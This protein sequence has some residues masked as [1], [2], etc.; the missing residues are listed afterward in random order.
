MLLLAEWTEAQSSG[1]TWM[2]AGVTQQSDMADD[3]R[4]AQIPSSGFMFNPWLT[5]SNL[6]VKGLADNLVSHWHFVDRNRQRNLKLRD[7]KHRDDIVRAV[8]ANLAYALAARYEPPTVYVSLRAA[9]QKSSPRYDRDGFRGLPRVLDLLAQYNLLHLERS[10]KK[11]VASSI[12]PSTQ[13]ME[14]PRGRVLAKLQ[15][16][17]ELPGRET[18]YL[19]RVD[20]DYAGASETRELIDYRETP[21]TTR[22]R[23]EMERING[24]L[25]PGD[26][27]LEDPSGQPL[28]TGLPYLRR[29][30]SLPPDAPEGT[31]RFDLGGRLF[32][33]WQ[34]LPKAQRSGI[35]I[36]G[37]AVAD[38]D[39]ANM[40]LRLAYLEAGH[41]PPEGDLYAAI[42]GL[43]EPRW[44]PGVKKA[45]LAMLFR[46]SPLTR[47]PRGTRSEL[48]PDLSG[49][50]LRGAILAGHPAL[51]GI[52]ETG[53]GLRLM[54]IE[55]Q[56]LVAALLTLA[57]KRIPAIPMHDGIMVAQ[58]KAHQATTIM[59]DAA[60]A[61]TGHRLPILLK[62]LY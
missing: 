36:K 42:P 29:H 60:E 49:P 15:E 10:S 33:W 2:T 47:I 35:R 14:G 52:F 59:G 43:S 57:D 39:F 40:A 62:S 21:E 22:Y 30:F 5:C 44:R 51:A 4:D 38:L 16:F 58:S 54:F 12:S 11:G 13:F 56:I 3:P 28:P 32:G 34:N 48:P 7:Q 53:I 46:G 31:E 8:L 26:F 61:I 1:A 24:S 23:A 6:F 41:L 50:Q 9:K 55:S 18:I 37:E 25:S 20:R 27:R 19:S 17:A 45:A